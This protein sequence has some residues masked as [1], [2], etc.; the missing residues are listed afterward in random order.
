[1]SLLVRAKKVNA[2]VPSE[3]L[4]ECITHHWAYSG[5][6]P[7]TGLIKCTLCNSVKPTQDLT[8]YE[9]VNR[10]ETH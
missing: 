4:K 6:V 7:C 1:M 2:L 10:Y 5:S 9:Q 3:R 8:V